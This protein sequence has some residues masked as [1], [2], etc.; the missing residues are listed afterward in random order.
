MP[1]CQAESSDSQFILLA[2]LF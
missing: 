2:L 1:F